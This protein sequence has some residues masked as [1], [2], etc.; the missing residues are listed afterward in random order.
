M[1]GS[2]ELADAYFLTKLH[3]PV[4][5]ESTVVQKTAALNEASRAIDRLR[6]KGT[7]V[8]VDEFPRNGIGSD[9]V[10]PRDIEIACYENAYALLDGIEPETEYANLA[11]SSQG[12]SSVRTTYDREGA[13][14]HLACG[15]ASSTAWNYLRPYLVSSQSIKLSRV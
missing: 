4:W 6:F 15:I 10:V 2:V 8:G 13:A 9:G 1:Y 3:C 7:K 11:I 12:Y 5:H 14:E